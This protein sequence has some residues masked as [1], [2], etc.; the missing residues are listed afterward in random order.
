MYLW[1]KLTP[2]QRDELMA[3]R[4]LQNL[5]W[6]SLAHRAGDKL[7]Y[8]LTAAC[9]EHRHVIGKDPGRMAAFSETL[10]RTLAPNAR[11]VLAWCVL[12]NH[13]HALVETDDVLAL[14][15]DIGK[16]HGRTSFDWNGEDQQRGR[17]VWFNCA[18]TSMKS[19]RHF[20]AT[21]NYV[22]HNPVHHGYVARWQ[23]WPFSSARAYLA[24]MGK[25]RAAELWREYPLLDYG[26]DWD[27]K[28]M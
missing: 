5:P 16:M 25:E 8:L 13:Y 4:R 22:H 7:R 2:K 28:E 1:R 3:F 12:P 27:G 11:R 20:W 14:L 23:D 26:K 24:E 15:R 21:L 19:E 9:F 10:L 6:H 18:E 17:Q